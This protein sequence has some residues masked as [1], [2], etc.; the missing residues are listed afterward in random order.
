[1]QMQAQQAAAQMAMQTNQ[2]ETQSKIAVK[3]AEIAF[4]IQKLQREA[5]LK[6][7]LMQVEFEM[8]MQLK[9]LDGQN[10]KNREN[11]RETAKNDRI[12]QQSTQTSK[13]IEQKKRDLPAI[14]FES[15]EDSLDGFDL[16]EFN[17][18]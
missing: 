5:Q 12:S 14:N 10:L 18:R 1:M 11:E 17:P 2:A 13:M 8:Q 3:E 16:A 7:E 4:D 9:G 15:N 6:Q